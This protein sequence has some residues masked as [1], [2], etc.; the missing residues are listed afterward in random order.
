MSDHRPTTDRPSD[1]EATIT[2][3][4]AAD[5]L[6][7]TV[8]AVRQRIKRGT[9]VRIETP[10]GPRIAWSPMVG[11]DQPPTD[12]K[13]PETTTPTT[14]TADLA[15]ELRRLLE[16]EREERRRAQQ[17]VAE[18]SGQVGYWQGQAA[19]FSARLDAL[20]AGD[21]VVADDDAPDR[22]QE[23]PGGAEAVPM[24]PDAP[25][26][27]PASWLRRLLGRGPS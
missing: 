7:I 3:E 23:A 27:R 10:S 11:R 19:A 12:P 4:E 1:H 2:F 20:A 8:N 25:R 6:G 13:R 22:G 16:D 26:P 17:R 14:G 24:A 15:D 5:R 21:P 9:L 18:L